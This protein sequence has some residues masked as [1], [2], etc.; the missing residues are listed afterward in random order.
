VVPPRRTLRPYQVDDAQRLAAV[1]DAGSNP[2]YVLPTGGGKTVVVAE[3]VRAWAARGLR[4][5]VIVHRKE[6]FDQ[7]AAQLRIAGVEPVALNAETRANA[8][9]EWRARAAR[10]GLTVLA[11]QQTAT[12]RRQSLRERLDA[13]PN[14]PLELAAAAARRRQEDAEQEE[15]SPKTKA[16]V[17]D[18][19]D[20]DKKEETAKDDTD[21]DKPKLPAVFDRVVVDEA[22]HATAST[23]RLLLEELAADAPTL[24]VTATPYRLNGTGLADVFDELVEGPSVRQLMR[25]GYLVPPRLLVRPVIA[26]SGVEILRTTGDFDT[27]ALS[28]AAQVASESVADHVTAHLGDRRGVAFGVDVEHSKSLEAALRRRGVAAAHVDGTTKAA[29]RA[30][31]IA[32]FRDGDVRVICNCEIVTEGFDVPDCSAI[33]LARPTRSRGLYIQMAGRGLRPREGKSDCLFFDF[34]GMLET[35]GAITDPVEYDLHTGLRVPKEEAEAPPAAARGRPGPREIEYLSQMDHLKY[36]TVAID[37]CPADDEAAS[38]TTTTTPTG[39]P[40]NVRRIA[41]SWG[42][43]ELTAEIETEL[44]LPRTARYSLFAGHRRRDDDDDDESNSVAADGFEAPFTVVVY[45]NRKAALSNHQSEHKNQPV[46]RANWFRSLVDFVADDADD[47]IGVRVRKHFGNLLRMQL[48]RQYKPG[49][50]YY[51]LRDRWGDAALKRLNYQ[52]E[53]WKKPALA[54]DA[55][56]ASTPDDDYAQQWGNVDAVD[57]YIP[58]MESRHGMHLRD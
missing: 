22:H 2:L 31:I 6:I 37:E 42:D 54:K 29:D 44:P 57:Q 20:A 10:E 1:V 4:T 40:L 23:Y 51:K 11:M 15:A 45:R 3:L 36:V 35:H 27:R 26:T 18:D 43:G 41:V 56:R 58:D 49:F 25:D 52:Y 16:D 5:L 17:D 38:T 8:P 7:T 48:R 47:Q 9:D 12:R 55:A 19:D 39:Q 46:T 21:A 13:S 32:Q 24:G 34:A 53:A 30:K 50:V 14:L 33:I 28:L